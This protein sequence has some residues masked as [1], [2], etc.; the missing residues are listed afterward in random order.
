M[1]EGQQ[2]QY[3]LRAKGR[4]SEIP[5]FENIILRTGDDGAIVRLRDVARIELGSANYGWYGRLNA[6]PSANLAVYQLPDANALD[7]ADGIKR[8][9]EVLKTRFPDDMDYKVAYDTTEYV[10]TSIW[11]VV[12]TLF[13]ALALVVIVVFVFLQDWRSTI[14]PAIAIP[15]S[16]IGT[17]AALGALGFSINTVSL[18]GLIWPSASWW[19]MRSWSL[20]TSSGICRTACRRK[21]RPG[22]RWRRSP[23]RSLPRLWC[24]LP[25]SCR[26]FSR[27]A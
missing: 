26:S 9:L 6:K 13:Q 7:V 12:V 25:S 23:A 18:F 10:K 2:F 27:P 16:L 14:I 19:T 20:R 3:A 24:C 21:R 11:G 8:Q 5:E 22:R 17:F 4:L 1:P 15:V